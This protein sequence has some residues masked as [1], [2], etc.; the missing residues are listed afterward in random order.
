MEKY[1]ER[2][3]SFT[4]ATL[5]NY[6]EEIDANSDFSIYDTMFKNFK[7]LCEDYPFQALEGLSK[8]DKEKIRKLGLKYAS[9]CYYDGKKENWSDSVESGMENDYQFVAAR[10]LDNFEYVLELAR[11]GGKDV[12]EEVAA[13]KDEDGFNDSCPI[14]YLRNTFYND[15]ILTKTLCKMASKEELYNL[16][17]E[18]QKADLLT[19]PEGTVYGFMDEEVVL[20]DPL[21]LAVEICHN[22]G[23]E[24]TYKNN[25]EMEK[26]A[27]K[28]AELLH[29]EDEYDFNDTVLNMADVYGKKIK[30]QNLKRPDLPIV[31]GDRE[32]TS[33][34]W[35]SADVKHI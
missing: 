31:N 2:L 1:E 35:A 20:A 34:L 26:A 10:I 23:N 14:E 19:F 4:K 21:S 18:K 24:V 6:L 16:F 3:E 27:L 12:L 13:L 22:L 11:V 33:K 8:E 5:Q 28:V 15:D 7:E 29:E 30:H 17:T 9:L 25:T 32:L